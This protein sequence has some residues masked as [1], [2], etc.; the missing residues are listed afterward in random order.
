MEGFAANK[1]ETRCFSHLS[2]YDKEKLFASL[3]LECL[4]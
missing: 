2:H 1:A 3:A 4:L